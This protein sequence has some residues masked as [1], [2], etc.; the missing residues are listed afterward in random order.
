MEGK[1]LS[2]II[3]ALIMILVM[4]R[5]PIIEANNYEYCLRK[6]AILCDPLIPECHDECMKAC[7]N[8]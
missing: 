3:V 6:C 1:G 5:D 2:R 4:I 7:V 8:Q